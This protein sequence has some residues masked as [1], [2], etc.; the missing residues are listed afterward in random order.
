MIIA[1][2]PA[3]HDAPEEET[4]EGN[5]RLACVPEAWCCLVH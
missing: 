5:G 4:L 1:C 3:A 2:F